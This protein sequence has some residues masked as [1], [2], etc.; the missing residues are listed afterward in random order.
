MCIIISKEKTAR[1]PKEEELKN[2]FEYNSDGAGF[3]YTEKGKV[4]IDKGY[5]D[6]DTFI[7]HYRNLLKRFNNFENKSLVIHCRIGTSGGNTR[8]NTHPYPISNKESLLHST[9]LITDIGI[10]HNGV[11]HGYGQVKGINDTQE[12]I[13]KYITPL[14]ENFKDFYKYEEIM[15]GIQKITNSKL[16]ILDNKDNIYYV[17]D[18]VEDED[19]KFSNTT[20]KS[21]KTYTTNYNYGKYY[22]YDDYYYDTHYKKND[23]LFALDKSKVESDKDEIKVEEVE[24]LLDDT[25]FLTPLAENY[26]VDIKG[27]GNNYERVGDRKLW[28]DWGTYY[29]YEEFKDGEMQFL[30]DCPIIYDSKFC[31]I[32]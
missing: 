3:M 29:L 17:G 22:D 28:F 8:A 24:D 23:T 4:V 25:E 32:N 9:K 15:K 1:L 31:E 16:A 11:I 30:S 27:T 26:Y 12:F 5:M 6:Y 13:M 21:Y 2:C 20:Y 19:L 10:A 7:R 14:Y 18:F